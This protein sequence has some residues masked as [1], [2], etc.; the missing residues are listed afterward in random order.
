MQKRWF[1]RQTPSADQIREVE[2]TLKVA[3]LMASLLIQRNIH[4]A[5]NARLFFKPSTDQLHDP[6]LMKDMDR[7]VDRLE[8]A[9]RNNEHIFIF[10]DYDVDGTSAVALL[11]SVLEPMATVSYYIP[12]RYEEGYGLSFTGVETAIAR[13]AGLLIALDCGIKDVE[14]IRLARENDLDVIVCDHHTPGPVLP[15]AIV[16]DPKRGDCAYPF[17]ELCGCGVGFKLLQGLFMQMQKPVT[18]LFSHLDLVAIAIGADI[19]PLTGENRVLC[20]L[21]LEQLNAHPRP[22][23]KALLQQAGKSFPLDLSN[24]VF[25]IAPRINAAGRLETGKKAVELLLTTEM[26]AASDIA[27]EIDRYNQE[28]KVLDAQITEEA[29]LQIADDALFES[30]KSTVVFNGQWHKGVVGIVAS[31]LMETHYRPTI[32]LTESKGLATG[33]AR[34]VD[35]FNVYEA[36]LACEHLLT[37]FGGHQYA[38]GLTLPLE[39]LE[40]FREAFDGIVRERLL[41]EAETPELTID[42]EIRLHQL[43]I[44]GESVRQVPRIMRMLNE[45]EPFGPQHEKP[46]FCVRSVYAS[47]SRILKEAHLKLDLFDPVS[48]VTLPAIGFNMAD[49]ADHV[50]SG[51]AFDCAFTLETNTWNDRTTLQLQ[52]RDIRPTVDA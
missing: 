12:D 42:Q 15:D 51:C 39:N 49:K 43:F 52:L 36:I 3:P 50:A 31:R 16:L 14:K 21:G 40:A 30:R 33:S 1:I 26:E 34:S 27:A 24:V 48:G 22:G 25:V 8:Q 41:K 29:L 37:Q 11:H 45:M 4:T 23:I 28:R 20:R 18:D 47:S 7:A 46:V 13:G 32:V 35:N 38:A 6:F 5:E 17:K 9:I 2:S 19:V 44:A 10:G